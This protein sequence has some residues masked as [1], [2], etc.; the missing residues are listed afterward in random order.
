MGA[1][2]GYILIDRGQTSLHSPINSPLLPAGPQR[3]IFPLHPGLADGANIH[4]PAH[5]P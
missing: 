5:L 4:P 3:T 2:P 1:R